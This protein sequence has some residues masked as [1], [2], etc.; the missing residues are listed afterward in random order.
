MDTWQLQDAKARL[1]EVVRRANK[2][3][4]QVISVRGKPEVVMLSKE[5]F[6]RLSRPKLSFA[7]FLRDSPLMGVSLD[8]ERDQSTD[9]PVN[10]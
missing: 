5:E 2:Q 1:S 4:P 9:R 7:D 6:D 3:G 8:I 10:L